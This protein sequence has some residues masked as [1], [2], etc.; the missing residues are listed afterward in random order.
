MS[1]LTIKN[2]KFV[3]SAVNRKS[4]PEPGPDEV[5]FV[6]RSNVGKSSLINALTNQRKLAKTSSTPGRTQ[7]INFYSLNH[8]AFRFID[9][10]GYGYAK[11]PVSIKATWGKMIEEY[12][13]NRPTLKLVV[14]IFDLRRELSQADLNLMFWL[15]Q[16]PRQV[17]IIFTK[18]DKYSK[19]AALAR[20]NQL[21][22][23]V[24]AFD[25]SPLLFSSLSGMGKKEILEKMKCF[26]D[27]IGE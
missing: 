7:L 9:L 10:P 18:A 24:T 16:I 5:A 4:W 3:T 26:L 27:S 22:P 21:K 12:L 1:E 23:I 6:G 17:M 8:D 14:N 2:G 11:A 19:G 13:Y 25:D 15:T 20:L